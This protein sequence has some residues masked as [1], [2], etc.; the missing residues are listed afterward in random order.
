MAYVRAQRKD[1][2]W[3]FSAQPERTDGNGNTVTSG[4]RVP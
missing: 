3:V 2:D 4:N 1:L